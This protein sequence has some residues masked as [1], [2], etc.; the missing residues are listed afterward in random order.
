MF[1]TAERIVTAVRVRPVSAH[2]RAAQHQ[3]I[4]SM[5][6]GDEAMPATG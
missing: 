6:G 4:V 1:A 5:G 3:V 2:E